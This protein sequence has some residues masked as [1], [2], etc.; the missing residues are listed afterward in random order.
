MTL[1]SSSCQHIIYLLLS[2]VTSFI[3]SIFFFVRVTQVYVNTGGK[4][5]CSKWVTVSSVFCSGV[6]RQR[7]S[8]GRTGLVAPADT[9]SPTAE[10]LPISLHPGKHTYLETPAPGLIKDRGVRVHVLAYT[11]PWTLHTWGWFSIHLFFYWGRVGVE[12]LCRHTV[13]VPISPR[14][15]FICFILEEHWEKG[16][17]ME[18]I[19]AGRTWVHDVDMQKYAWII[20][21]A[22]RE[23]QQQNYDL[24]V[25]QH[26]MNWQSC[27]L[28]YYL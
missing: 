28:G 20:A 13:L 7:L 4:I 26:F 22:R 14:M 27:C 17:W 3:V 15:Y 16:G 21:E 12:K 1:V 18:V 11:Q 25:L 23:A 9:V 6:F 5:K 8:V 10:T 24:W 19:E 2:V